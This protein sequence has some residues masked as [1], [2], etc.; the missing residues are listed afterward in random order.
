M[1][2][3]KD[4]STVKIE[5][6]GQYKHIQIAEDTVI[7]ED[8]TEISRTRHRKT[9]SCGSLSTDGK[10]DFVATDI[11]GESSVVQNIASTVWT[12]SVEEAWKAKMIADKV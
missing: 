1:A 5:V 9:Y 8:G 3:S 6:V 4:T 7:K 2:L 10:D 11:S 12:Q